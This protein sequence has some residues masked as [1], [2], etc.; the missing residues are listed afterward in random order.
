MRRKIALVTGGVGGIGTAV[1]K[2]LAEAGHRVVANYAVPGT[3][4]HFLE[5]IRAAGFHDALVA[6]GDVADYHAMGEMVYNITSDIG[7]VD[8]LVN[9]A[10]ITRDGL[11]RK[12]S[13]EDWDAVINVNLSGAFNL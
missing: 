1:C 5:Q 3:E 8:I 9:C 7:P 2:C 11:F 6:L 12:M 13:K 4:I 10:G